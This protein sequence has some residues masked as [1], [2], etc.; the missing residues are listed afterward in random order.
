MPQPVVLKSLVA[1]ELFLVMDSLLPSK[2][3]HSGL[4]WRMLSLGF[5]HTEEKGFSLMPE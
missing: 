4:V 1:S 5:D 2:D 3:I